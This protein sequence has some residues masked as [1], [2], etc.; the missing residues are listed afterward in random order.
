LYIRKD[1]K[2]EIFGVQSFSFRD[3]S[4][5]KALELHI[6]KSKNITTRIAYN[7]GF[8]KKD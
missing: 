5:A 8:I 1:F 2:N 6:K 3:G 4:K 7:N